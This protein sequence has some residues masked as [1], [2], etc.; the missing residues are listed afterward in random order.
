MPDTKLW[1]NR[2]PYDKDSSRIICIK[3]VDV[4]DIPDD[5]EGRFRWAKDL[6]NGD[7]D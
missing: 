1:T 4:A 5:D 2:P 6:L 3:M 7:R